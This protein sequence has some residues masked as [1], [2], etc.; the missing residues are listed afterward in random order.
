MR[1]R[2]NKMVLGEFYMMY[3]HVIP[4]DIYNCFVTINGVKHEAHFC[5][6]YKKV[7]FNE[8]IELKG[9]GKPLTI[10]GLAGYGECPIKVVKHLS[11]DNNNR[12]NV[13]DYF[14]NFNL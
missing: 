8:P 4:R 12:F 9:Y 5:P 1:L 6:E 14:K 7:I 13:I 10:G 11:L 2:V 3:V